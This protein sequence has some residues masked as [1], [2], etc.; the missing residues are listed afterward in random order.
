MAL[1]RMFSLKGDESTP[2]PELRELKVHIYYLVSILR[3]LPPS[4]TRFI[5][6]PCASLRMLGVIYKTTLSRYAVYK[7]KLPPDG[8][9]NVINLF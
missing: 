6:N 1:E 8:A 9:L 7:I 2:P 5:H 4:E 3:R